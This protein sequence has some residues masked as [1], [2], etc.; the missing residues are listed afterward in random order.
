MRPSAPRL[1]RPASSP[2]SSVS[3]GSSRSFHRECER[4]PRTLF[5]PPAPMPVPRPAH[6][7]PRTPMMDARHYRS[8]F[9]RCGVAPPTPRRATMSLRQRQLIRRPSWKVILRSPTL[10][11]M[12]TPV[13][14]MCTPLMLPMDLSRRVPVW[15]LVFLADIPP[16]VPR[17]AVL[18]VMERPLT[19]RPVTVH[20]MTI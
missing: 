16:I 10:L 17:V 9:P 18:L 7:V 6:P 5:L 11:V 20:Q 12:L 1:P 2:S 4:S 14:M 19:A 3:S 13:V 15:V 8:L